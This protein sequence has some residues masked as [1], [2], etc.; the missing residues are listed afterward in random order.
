MQDDRG[1]ENGVPLTAKGRKR[2]G[3]RPTE[4]GGHSPVHPPTAR[5]SLVSRLTAGW[6]TWRSEYAGSGILRRAQVLAGLRKSG[7]R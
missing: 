2:L 3:I 4:Q 7:V 1:Q 5:H 6:G